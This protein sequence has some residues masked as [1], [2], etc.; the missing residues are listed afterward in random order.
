[1]TKK[2]EDKKIE[3]KT[4]KKMCRKKMPTSAG[5]ALGV[6]CPKE[7]AD[8]LFN[9]QERHM[10]DQQPARRRV[11][12]IGGAP[13]LQE[14]LQAMQQSMACSQEEKQMDL[15]VIA[16]I[17]RTLVENSDM[18]VDEDTDDSQP[19]DMQSQLIQAS[20]DVHQAIISIAQDMHDVLG[21][22]IGMMDKLTYLVDKE[23]SM[24]KKYAKVLD[25]ANE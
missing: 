9:K 2:P 21:K 18:P 22:L 15:A 10:Q 13:D 25:A 20:G 24:Y 11:A 23:Q 6:A 16:D 3:K 14:V 19:E 4:T 17:L 5:A 7:L 1:M 8:M 12:I